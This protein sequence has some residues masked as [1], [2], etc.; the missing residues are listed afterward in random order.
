MDRRCCR[1]PKQAGTETE[2]GSPGCSADSAIAVGRSLSADLGAERGESRPAATAVAPAPDG[3]DAHATDEPVA[4]GGAERRS[5]PQERF[6]AGSRT[7]TT[8]VVPVSPVGEPAPARLAGVAGSTDP[9]DCGT[10]RSDRA[11]S[12]EVSRGAAVENASRGR[13]S[14][15]AGFRIDHREGGAVP[16]RQTDCELSGTGALGGVQRGSATAGTHHQTGQLAVA[17]PA[18]GGSPSHGAQ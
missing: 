14:D 12:R 2:N 5:A 13:F 16:V 11:G 7:E 1:D 4:G 17:F 10:E 9:D 3:A 8:R 15:R 6:V 18:G